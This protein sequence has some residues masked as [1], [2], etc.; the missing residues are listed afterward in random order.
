MGGMNSKTESISS[1]RKTTVDLKTGMT[2]VNPSENLP[3]SIKMMD[4]FVPPLQSDSTIWNSTMWCMPDAY[5]CK[6]E[7][8]RGYSKFACFEANINN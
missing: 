4:D 1:L 2:A 6:N 8:I 3:I 5:F 7:F